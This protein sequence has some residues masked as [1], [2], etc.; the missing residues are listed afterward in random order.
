M[1]AASKGSEHLGAGAGVYD[2]KINKSRNLITEFGLSPAGT[3]S[4]PDSDKTDRNG[5]RAD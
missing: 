2:L 3:R 1:T 5:F 4:G